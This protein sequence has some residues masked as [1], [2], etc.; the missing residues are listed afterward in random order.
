MKTVAFYALVAG[1]AFAMAEYSCDEGWVGMW[2]ASGMIGE[3]L[4]RDQAQR[5]RGRAVEH[6]QRHIG[7]CNE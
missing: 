5:H 6:R 1:L 2:G 7:C 3:G 4:A